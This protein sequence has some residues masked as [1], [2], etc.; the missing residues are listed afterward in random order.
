MAS[1]CPFDIWQLVVDMAVEVGVE[2]VAGGGGRGGKQLIQKQ[3]A[4]QTPPSGDSIFLIHTKLMR[5]F[6]L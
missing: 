2:M 5:L 6:Y 4:N 3:D 1:P